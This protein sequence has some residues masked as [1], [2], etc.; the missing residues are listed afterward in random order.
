MVYHKDGNNSDVIMVDK[1][2]LKH[3]LWWS[4]HI[5]LKKTT[6]KD[7]KIYQKSDLSI[8]AS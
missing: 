5:F 3:D 1:T 8:I 7:P 4:V 2:L 6:K